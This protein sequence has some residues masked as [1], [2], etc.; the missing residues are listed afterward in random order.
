MKN[1]TST[2]AAVA[3]AAVT[4][5]ALSTSA[6]A[7]RGDRA[8]M[9]RGMGFEMNFDAMD[10]D[11]DGKL[12]E[13]EIDT[14]RKAEAAKADADGD[15]K[16]SAAELAAAHIARATTE[17][18]TRAAEMIASLDSDGDGLLSAAEMTNR[19]LPARL[20]DR[21]DA[22]SDGAV[23]KAEIEAVRDRMAE[24]RHGKKRGDGN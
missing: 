19:P 13:A 2:L 18:N 8:G 10:A 12:T 5:A 11:K 24:G 16:M 17:A 20:F 23:T 22:D 9:G 7:D 14:Y 1:L 4:V 3:L 21:I 6:W 15:G